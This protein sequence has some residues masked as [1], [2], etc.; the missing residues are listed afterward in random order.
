M[1]W[2]VIQQGAG[3]DRRETAEDREMEKERKRLFPSKAETSLMFM[4]LLYKYVDNLFFFLPSLHRKLP[5][6]ITQA[7]G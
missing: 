5:P 2:L 3:R 4:M 7:T 1:K 6:K